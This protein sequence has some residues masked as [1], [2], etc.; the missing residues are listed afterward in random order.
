[1]SVSRS[2]FYKW[3]YRQEH[4]TLK[5]LSRQSDINLI[6]EIHEK[7]PSHGYRWINA[8]AI[9]HY[10]I[11]W[12]DNHVHLCCKYEGIKSH[13]KHYQWKKP[14]EEHEKFNN[15]VK[16]L[17][18]DYPGL[19]E[20][21]DEENKKLKISEDILDKKIS[22]TK[23][24]AEENAKALV[25]QTALE[26]ITEKKQ[27]VLKGRAGFKEDFVDR[28][29]DQ[30]FKTTANSG[31]EIEIDKGQLADAFY[32]YFQKNNQDID[33]TIKAIEEQAPDNLGVDISEISSTL[34]EFFNKY[35][36]DNKIDFSDTAKTNIQNSSNELITKANENTKDSLS[37]ALRNAYD[38]KYQTSLKDKDFSLVT[39]PGKYTD[40][41]E[42]EKKQ[43]MKK[44]ASL[45]NAD[46]RKKFNQV[47]D[48]GDYLQ[49]IIDAIIADSGKY[50]EYSDKDREL[51]KLLG[52]NN[53]DDLSDFTKTY[54]TQTERADILI[55]KLQAV[56]IGSNQ[57]SDEDIKKVSALDEKLQDIYNSDMNI[58]QAEASIKKIREE[59]KD[60]TG[61]DEIIAKYEKDKNEYQNF[62]DRY[63]LNDTKWKDVSIQQGKSVKDNLGKYLDNFDLGKSSKDKLA[64]S[65]YDSIKGSG[66]NQKVTDALFDIDYTELSKGTYEDAVKIIQ[67][68][69]EA[70]DDSFKDTGEAAARRYLDGLSGRGL[71]SFI[72]KSADTL[73]KSINEALEEKL[74]FSKTFGDV[75]SKTL[76]DVKNLGH[77][78]MSNLKDLQDKITSMGLKPE[79]FLKTTDQGNFTLDYEGF[80]EAAEQQLGTEEDFVKKKEEER[81]LGIAQLELEISML[82]AQR[83]GKTIEDNTLD[84]IEKI[85]DEKEAQARLQAYI[86][87]QA[88]S[89]INAIVDNLNRTTTNKDDFNKAIDAKIEEKRKQIQLLKDTDI[90]G[91][92]KKE[93][94]AT[95]NYLHE[96]SKEYE[97]GIEDLEKSNNDA[98]KNWIDKTKAVEEAKKSLAKAIETV[99]EKQKEL[100]EVI[101]GTDWE[102]SLDGMYNYDTALDSLVKQTER[103]KKKLDKSMSEDES[104]RNAQV[105]GQSLLNQKANIGAQRKVYEQAIANYNKAYREK[106]GPELNKWEDQSKTKF[107]PSKYVKLNDKTGRYE[108]SVDKLQKDKLPKQVKSWVENYVKTVNDYQGKIE[109]LR[110]KE[111]ELD[112]QYLEWKRQVRDDYIDLQQKMMDVLREKY[113]KE[114][115]DL[116]NK[117]DAMEEADQ[118]YL[119][120]LQKNL[121]KQ[122]KLRDQEKNWRE[123]TDKERKLSL[124]Q[125]DTS[126]GNTGEIKSLEKEIEDQ[127]TSLLDTAVDDIIEKLQEFYNLQKESRDAEI[128]YKETLL[129][130]V[131]LLKE[132]TEELKKIHTSQ[133]L[134]NW[135]KKNVSNIAQMSEEEFNREKDEWSNLIKAK[136][137]YSASI[138]KT[139]E[140][141]IENAEGKLKD[142][143]DETEKVVKTTSEEITKLADTTLQ[144]AGEEYK[145]AIKAAKDALAD[146]VDAVQKQKDALQSALDAAEASK[147]AFDDIHKAYMEHLAKES[148]T[149]QIQVIYVNGKA[150]TD[151]T[152]AN[153]AS[154]AAAQSGHNGTQTKGTVNKGSQEHKDAIDRSKTDNSTSVFKDTERYIGKN[155]S[156]EIVV[157]SNKSSF[158]QYNPYKD[159]RETMKIK[160]NIQHGV[161]W[162]DGKKKEWTLVKG[163]IGNETKKEAEDWIEKNPGYYYDDRGIKIKKDYRAFAQGGLVDYTGPAWVDGSRSRPEAFLSAE[164]TRRIGEAARILS[165]LPILSQSIDKDKITNNTIGDTNIQIEVNVDQIANDYDV[166]EAV[167][168]VEQKIIEAAKYAG[169][170]VILKKR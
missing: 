77:I 15:L 96:Q 132:V 61:A 45:G 121:D 31:K 26:D 87:G 145:K 101:K 33:A 125:R 133:D 43:G 120:A 81:D 49:K 14:D 2:G 144:E 118:N 39:T 111:E 23:E 97:K 154:A 147:K 65:L 159:T 139:F 24:L 131:N 51:F 32:D 102:S 13:G 47:G 69:L 50:D 73:N 56:A 60:I 164:D 17:Q 89:E 151:Q 12:T 20:M 9:L 46:F 134:V 63:D 104:K 79:D 41:S 21:Y 75:L 136:Q 109:D 19:I 76:S 115:D 78:D 108:I 107:D 16:T 85:T 117:Y 44:I 67:Q 90:E 74:D 64:N 155:S 156:G 27:E 150:Y 83:D 66:F 98:Y 100:A 169:S 95:V 166:D 57:L 18:D 48:N 113:Q 72:T 99:K 11:I 36:T 62:L 59:S 53:Q 124:M 167:N 152:A 162:Y 141:S 94:Q 30:V 106:L 4:P 103:A 170:N 138:D 149:E 127:R 168:R 37:I 71:V 8:Y 92:A 160:E 54:K 128:E 116:Q 1:M 158:N 93:F 5:M 70:A 163:F 28:F 22:K 80:L 7:H 119:D 52:I 110:D 55:S 40:L 140:K 58:A 161:I 135:W 88:Q 165:D 10:G 82:E 122:R 34:R 137:N 6:K 130:D 157:Y 112:E 142:V 3:K 123:L 143:A 86:N 68:R 114:I 35:K 91:Q 105:Y 153:R 25:N 126:R 29:K 129:S 84:T 42:D 38:K 146:A 148:K